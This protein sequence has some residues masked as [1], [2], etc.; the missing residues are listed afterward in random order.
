MESDYEDE[1][2]T[3]TVRDIE[4]EVSNKRRKGNHAHPDI[5]MPVLPAPQRSRGVVEMHPAE[6]LYAYLAFKF[7]HCQSVAIN[8]LACDMDMYVKHTHGAAKLEQ[9]MLF[10]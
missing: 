9:L 1:E 2:E 4:Q 10:S 7:G 8:K 3:R 5:R 6:V